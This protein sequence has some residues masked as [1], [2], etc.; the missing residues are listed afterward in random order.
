[1]KKIITL[2]TGLALSLAG[3]W[4]Q[5]SNL[6][7]MGGFSTQPYTVKGESRSVLGTSNGGNDYF[8]YTYFFSDHFGIFAQIGLESVYSDE[9]PFFG[10]MNKA[11]GSKYLYR[12]NYS[13]YENDMNVY[14]L[15]AAYRWDCGAFRFTPRL[16]IGIGDFMGYDYSYERRSRNG[17]SGPEYFSFTPVQESVSYDYLI[18][19]VQ[20]YY[21]PS[22]MLV[23]ADFQIS[24]MADRRFYLFVQPGVTL[25]PFRIKVEQTRC[26]SSRFYNPTNWVEALAYSDAADSWRRDLSTQT[27]SVKPFF[28]SPYFHL[29]V[30]IGLNFGFRNK[31]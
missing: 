27:S 10:A 12:F 21:N 3:A 24:V 4:A 9:A 26:G 8:R 23:T 19:D 7:F 22:P 15:G 18:D 11:D 30:G 28:I 13:N 31:R 17:S 16:G 5:N 2:C 29:N 6:E 14:S 1:M 25:A 20:T